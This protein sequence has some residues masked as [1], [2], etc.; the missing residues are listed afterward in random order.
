[1][2]PIPSFPYRHETKELNDE[3][4]KEAASGAFVRLSDGVT[5]YEFS[6]PLLEGEGGASR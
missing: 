1:M 6:S 3:T 2:T 4:R 5:H